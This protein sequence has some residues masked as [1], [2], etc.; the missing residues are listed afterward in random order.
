MEKKEIRK[1]KNESFKRIPIK[2]KI[3]LKEDNILEL[4]EKFVLP[5][6][7]KD[8]ILTI[9]ESPLAITQGRAVLV[10]ELKIGLLA[11]NFME[12]CKKNKA[13]HRFAFTFKYAMCD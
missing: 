13:R 4:V 2:T 6:L 12:I 8:D 5:Y 9:S 3:I 11:K 10:S 1:Y 7:K